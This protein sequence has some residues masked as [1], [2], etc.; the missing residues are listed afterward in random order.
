VLGVDQIFRGWCQQGPSEKVKEAKSLHPATASN[1]EGSWKLHSREEIRCL[2][3][4]N[5]SDDGA[6]KGLQRRLRKQ[7]YS[8]RPQQPTF[9]AAG[10][11]SAG[12][13]E[14]AP[15]WAKH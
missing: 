7:S 3:L 12:K 9:K 15:I 6:S 5:F 14:G 11:C 1:M 13:E 8:T 10:S 4:I 2:E